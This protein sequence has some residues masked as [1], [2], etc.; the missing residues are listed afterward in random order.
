MINGIPARIRFQPPFSGRLP[1]R[2]FGSV[3]SST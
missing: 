3:C 1:K 2:M